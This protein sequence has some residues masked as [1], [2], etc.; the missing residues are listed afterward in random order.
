MEHPPHGGND[1]GKVGT[2]GTL[3]KDINLQIAQRLKKKL[4]EEGLEVV[5]TRESDRNLAEEDA[6]SQ[7]VSDLKHRV[8][9]IGE[10]DPRLVVSIHQNSYTDASARGAQVF[11]YSGSGEGEELADLL[12][13]HLIETADPSNTRE[14]KENASYYMLKRTP[15]VTVIAECGFLS[16]PEEEQLLQEEDYQEKIAEALCRGVMEYLNLRQDNRETQ[17]EVS[18]GQS[19]PD[20]YISRK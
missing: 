17:M 2:D 5:L 3:E 7:K 8:E 20:V 14:A 16:N 12:Q 19:A 10:T 6:S 13:K 9:L 18:P 15:V 1:P 11:Y 4:Q